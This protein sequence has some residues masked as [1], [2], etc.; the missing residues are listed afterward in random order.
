MTQEN[1]II[2][3]VPHNFLHYLPLHALKVK[4]RYLIDRNP[5][6]YTP[7]A[8]VMKYCHQKRKKRRDRALIFADS[9][10]DRLHTQVQG[11]AIEKLF[12]PD[13]DIYIGKQVT[14][15]LLK[16]K[17]RESKADIDI[18]HIAC[19]GEFN[20][21][22]ALNSGIMFA[23]SEKLTAEE[24]FSLDL[25]AYLVT[26]S[27]CE[28]GINENKPGDELIGLTRA[29]I[30]AGTPSVVVSLWSVEQISTSIFMSRFYQKL[31]GGVNKASALQQAQLEL[32]TMTAQDVIDYCT[33][34]KESLLSN[35]GMI[36]GS[37]AE[38][39]LDAH[40]ANT[41]F[42]IG[43]TKGAALDYERL[44]AKAIPDTQEYE[45]L[46]NSL[47]DCEA[48]GLRSAPDAY[49]TLVYNNVYYWAAFVLIGDWK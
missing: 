12:N 32:Q 29:F 14:K 30:Y 36:E 3:L 26:L 48:V 7:S 33:K 20:A 15:N 34:A 44:L 25:N 21:T 28:S 13:A 47:L 49:Q 46:D 43:D 18:L 39:L 4:N 40:I 5:I 9:R 24:I 11:I 42:N 41:R 6:C 35:P 27:A 2:W 17:L 16:Q 10:E 23:Q 1:D 8:S 19:H 31:K 22:E 38:R 45:D 37:L